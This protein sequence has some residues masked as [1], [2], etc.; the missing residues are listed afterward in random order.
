MIEQST[1]V[2]GIRPVIEAIKAGKEIDRVFVQKGL[3][4]ELFGELRK[5]MVDLEIPFQ[6][7]P[8]EK[9][10][11][12]T[13]KNHQGIV[14]IITPIIF[15]HVEDILPIVYEEGK[16]PLILVLDGITDVRNFGSIA[17]TAECAGVNAIVVPAKGSAQINGDA[18]KTS[19]GA[20]LTIPVCRVISLAKTVEF[21]QQSGLR[22]VACTEKA[23]DDYFKTDFTVPTAIVMGAED[24]GISTDLI[25]KADYLARIPILGDISSLN[26]AVATGVV[27]YEVI[28]QRVN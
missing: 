8:V 13:R 3:Q 20:L 15:Q 14:C 1:M 2:F 12:L 27:L 11:R 28:R 19:A 4:G 6:I 5:L 22:I 10:D 9:L 24:T 23:S 7:V 21:L 16:T 26:V 18:I 17:R 25:K